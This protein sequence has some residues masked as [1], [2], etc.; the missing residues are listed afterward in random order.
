MCSMANLNTAFLDEVTTA[1]RMVQN[2]E[3]FRDLATI[4]C[5]KKAK[6]GDDAVDADMGNVQAFFK[7]E[8][9]RSAMKKGQGIY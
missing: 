4:P 1:L 2:H 3:K 6:T 8:K 9:F 7:L 5:E